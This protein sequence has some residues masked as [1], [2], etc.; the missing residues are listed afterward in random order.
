M[1]IRKIVIAPNSILDKP[2]QKVT[3]I[4]S[5][6]KGYIKDIKDTLE[7][8]EVPGAGLAANQVGIDK[9]ICVVRDFYIGEGENETFKEYVLVNPIIK[10][11]SQKQAMDWEGCLSVPDTF[12]L[13]K[14]YKK[15]RVDALDENG[16]KVKIDA[17]GFFARTIQHEVDH[18]NGIVFTSKIIGSKKTERE[19]DNLYA[20]KKLG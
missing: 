10:I 6:I 17:E 3:E 11:S 14:R 8:S 18:L 2:C 7:N 13:V 1:S 15:I 16:N 12:G 4:N 5:E 9:Q 20:T 19:L